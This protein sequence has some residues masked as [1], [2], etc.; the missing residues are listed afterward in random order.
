MEFIKTLLIF[1]GSAIVINIA[2]MAM[3][4]SKSRD[5]LY[6]Y[7]IYLWVGTLGNFILQAVFDRH[8]L[9]MVLSFSTYFFCSSMLAKMLANTASFQS[10]QKMYNNIFFAGL[11]LSVLLNFTVNS[12]TITALPTAIGVAFPMLHSVYFYRLNVKEKASLS[13]LFSAIVFLN[14]LHFLDYPFLR[15]LPEMAAFGFSFAFLLVIAMSV[16]IPIYTSKA[17]SDRHLKN[18]L[19]EV[20][21]RKESE[22]RLS[23]AKEDA[24]IATRVKSEFLANMSHE[25][26]TPMNGI[27]GMAQLMLENDLSEEA[28]EFATTIRNCSESLLTILNDLLEFSKAES[29]KIQ[30]NNKHFSIRSCIESSVYIFD[31]QASNKQITLSYHIADLVPDQIFSDPTRLRQIMMNLIGN[32]IKFTERGGIKI[33][34]DGKFLEQERFEYHFQIQ[35]TG[36]GIPV[37]EQEKIFNSFYQVQS[38][39]DRK[40]GGTG[41]GLAICKELV[42]RWVEK[43]V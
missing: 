7:S 35:D 43:L 1:Y 20:N 17:L 41:L 36:I 15:P 31:A 33:S 12:F 27:I 26:R 32:S 40:Y 6:L 39:S 29:G 11:A 4:W 38:A 24:E 42:K 18:L 34:V 8:H 9:S 3:L 2:L 16:F 13:N 19:T 10:K 37:A 23:K 21:R 5:R 14:A 25:I 22:K 30:I 28:R